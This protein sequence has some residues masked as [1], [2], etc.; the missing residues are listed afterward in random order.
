MSPKSSLPPAGVP[1]SGGNTKY[2]LVAVVLLLGVG[3]IFAWRSMTNRDSAP[4][5]VPTV[6]STVASLAAPPP[7]PKLDD[8]PPPPPVEEKPE[9]GT[10]GGGHFVAAVGGG[11]CES[12]CSGKATAEL[13]A[14]LQAR[15]N[16][17]RR[18]YNSALANDSSLRGHVTI[19]VKVGPGG[20]VCSAS[21]AANDMS[22]PAV[23]NCAA[24]IL[25]NASYPA[26]KGGCVL[27][28][29]PLSFVPMGQ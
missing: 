24:N 25:R 28:T 10:G 27:A 1:Q 26:P 13:G 4:A 19:A 14:A 17:A 23:A 29:V 16:Q 12:A 3:G 5:P 2:A 22:S 20:N 7:N 11:G 21:V 18:C 9:G 8:I 15:G 6:P